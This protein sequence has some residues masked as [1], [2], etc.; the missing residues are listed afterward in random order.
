[1]KFGDRVVR[2][3]NGDRGT[4]RQVVE[5]DEW[6][7][8]YAWVA[9]DG[10]EENEVIDIELR[11]LK[12]ENAN[13]KKAYDIVTLHRVVAVTADERGD[14]RGTIG[15]YTTRSAAEHAAS[16]SKDAPY[17]GIRQALAILVAGEYFLLKDV[18]PVEVNVP[19]ETHEANATRKRAMAKLTEAEKI[20]LG[21]A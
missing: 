2:E 21:L 6:P 13:M 17:V 9:I 10:D 14:E 15:A 12:L 1:M 19:I 16:L 7:K 5:G 8:P 4:I 18:G 20:A 3:S 11:H